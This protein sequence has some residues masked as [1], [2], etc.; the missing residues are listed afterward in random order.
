MWQ[1]FYS[2]NISLLNTNNEN[3]ISNTSWAW[4]VECLHCRYLS[5][6]LTESISSFFICTKARV[7]FKRNWGYCY[8]EYTGTVWALDSSVVYSNNK[9]QYSYQSSFWIL[10]YPFYIKVGTGGAMIC[11]KYRMLPVCRADLGMAVCVWWEIPLRM[12][13]WPQTIKETHSKCGG[14]TGKIVG[15]Q[16]CNHSSPSHPQHW[17][18]TRCIAV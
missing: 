2:S 6:N 10:M 9:S 15:V 11:T 17:E 3:F 8:W 1:L 7:S 4:F 5:R 12:I 16:F 13:Q 18:S 14:E